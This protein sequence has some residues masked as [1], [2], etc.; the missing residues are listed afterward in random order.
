MLIIIILN[1]IYIYNYMIMN[2]INIRVFYIESP[3]VHTKFLNVQLK[4][5]LCVHQQVLFVLDRSKSGILVLF[6]RH[7]TLIFGTDTLVTGSKILFG[8]QDVFVVWHGV[9]KLSFMDTL[10]A[11]LGRVN[12]QWQ[13]VPYSRIYCKDQSF[14]CL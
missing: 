1:F 4:V 10:H 2:I 8:V 14:C 6:V 13:K 7:H 9:L 11:K 12:F 5:Q 3:N